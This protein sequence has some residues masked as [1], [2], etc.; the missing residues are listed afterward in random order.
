MVSGRESS[1]DGDSA[2]IQIGGGCQVDGDSGDDSDGSGKGALLDN[3]TASSAAMQARTSKGAGLNPYH[4]LVTYALTRVA[5]EGF[6]SSYAKR[7]KF[8]VVNK[9]GYSTRPPKRSP[10]LD[11]SP[12]HVTARSPQQACMMYVITGGAV[13]PPR[14][15]RA[16]LRNRTVR[17]SMRTF[18]LEA[19]AALLR[20]L[21]P[22]AEISTSRGAASAMQVRKRGWGCHGVPAATCGVFPRGKYCTK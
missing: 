21:A 5:A 14:V 17:A 12:F 1:D 8:T 13:A 11:S 9:G 15:L 18:G 2:P 20:S 3:E 7:M 22:N 4:L 10:Y 6:L 16:S 19:L